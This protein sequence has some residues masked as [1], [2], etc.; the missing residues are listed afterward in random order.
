MTPDLHGYRFSV[1][2]WI[3]RLAF[4]QKGAAYLWVEIDPFDLPVAPAYLALNPFGRVPTLVHGGFALYETG[5]ITEYLDEAFDGPALMPGAAKARARAR[6]VIAI[7]AGD[8]YWPLVRQVFAHGFWRARTG[9]GV[10]RAEVVKGL[11]AA[12]RVLGAL[13]QIAAEGLVLSGGDVTLADIHL[14]PM[15]GYF[16]ETA[17]GAAMLARYPALSRRWEG[18]SA[19]EGYLVTRP[20]LTGTLE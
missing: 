1:F 7:V 8:A 2:A 19:S 17:E 20:D 12:P 6:Q 11:E 4:H 14:A 3:A 9:R 13:D 10:D 15:I 5:A 16:C 18:M